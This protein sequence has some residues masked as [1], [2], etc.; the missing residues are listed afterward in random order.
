[1]KA[2]TTENFCNPFFPPAEHPAT[3][4]ELCEALLVLS[5]RSVHFPSP[6]AAEKIFDAVRECKHLTNSAKNAI[7]CAA[8]TVDWKRT[9][10][11]QAR[12]SISSEI[13]RYWKD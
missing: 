11:T 3:P 10:L 5:W 1:M 9:T 6:F 13:K 7:I 12:K 8:I 4:G 2:Q